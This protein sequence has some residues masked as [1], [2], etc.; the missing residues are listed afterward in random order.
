[1][2]DFDMTK[3]VALTDISRLFYKCMQA[4]SLAIL[5]YKLMGLQLEDAWDGTD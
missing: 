4:I 2:Y 1:M 3:V 5:H